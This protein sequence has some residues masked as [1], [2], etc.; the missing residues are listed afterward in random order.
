MHAEMKLVGKQMISNSF[1]I[2]S[3]DPKSLKKE[4]LATSKRQFREVMYRLGHLESEE[5]K[6]LVESGNILSKQIAF[7]ACIRSYRFI[8]DFLNEVVLEKISLFDYS[9]TDR[10]YFSFLR[11]KELEHPE[12]GQLADSTK[13]KVKQVLFRILYQTELIDSS[14]Q[15][16]INPDYIDPTLRT[17]LGEEGKL[18]EV[19]LLLG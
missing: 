19:K 11:R 16:N 10:D 2:S 9:I 5:V 17:W 18:N 3:L 15:R 7:L 14:M 12:I 1:L 13:D 4:R 6:M 8:Y